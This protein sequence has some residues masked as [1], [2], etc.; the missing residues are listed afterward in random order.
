MKY[1]LKWVFVITCAAF[2]VNGSISQAKD[3]D[4]DWALRHKI[5][6]VQACFALDELR[7]LDRA[8]DQLTVERS[9][10]PGEKIA[11][12]DLREFVGSRF[13]RLHETLGDPAGPKDKLGN[14]FPPFIAGAM[15]KMNP[16]TIQTLSDVVLPK[17]WDLAGERV[18]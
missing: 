10:K 15:A 12:L 8:I 4:E 13:V 2:L 6:N 5:H 14:P 11:P 3:G 17:F 1:Y 18:Q 16:K 9:K 7:E